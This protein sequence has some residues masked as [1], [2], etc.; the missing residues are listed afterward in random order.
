MPLRPFTLSGSMRSDLTWYA[1]SPEGTLQVMGATLDPTTINGR[2]SDRFIRPASDFNDEEFAASGF[3]N[4]AA[5]SIAGQDGSAP[6]KLDGAPINTVRDL[7]T[8]V[9][10]MR[11]QGQLI[12]VTWMDKLRR[13]IVKKF[14]EK[15]QTTH[16]LEWSITF[17]WMSQDAFAL[18]Q[19]PVEARQFDFST[20]INK[21]ND[22]LDVINS[23]NLLTT[24]PFGSIK[25]AAAALD[26]GF[27]S[28]AELVDDI[29]EGVFDLEDAFV[30]S[31]RRF[32]SAQNT[33]RRIA[34]TY[35][36]LKRR[37]AD[38]SLLF[39]NAQDALSLNETDD[40]GER[41]SERKA[42]R[43]QRKASNRVGSVAAR[44][45]QSVLKNL[46]PELVRAFVAR[47][48]QDLREVA[49][50][51]YGTPDSWQSLLS[52]NNLATSKLEA[53]QLVLVPRNPPEVEC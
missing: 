36:F 52:Y 16:V 25:A 7:A 29:Q 41:L 13:G 48:D 31:T 14:E 45:Q 12:Q 8:L 2:W 9:D 3:A 10:D 27:K 18:N 11:R 37:S 17:E 47:E 49:R 22:D 4:V 20:S 38:L 44:N 42:T 50:L 32:I 5:P 23:G 46:N 1:G 30:V 19:E 15:W 6:A 34:G 24:D 21:M 33:S 51:H 40:L 43:D 39:D 26:A 53:G 28:I 35:D